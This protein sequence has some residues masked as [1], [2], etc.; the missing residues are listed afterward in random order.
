M[1]HVLYGLNHGTL[2]STVVL[3]LLL[4]RRHDFDRPGDTTTRT[5]VAARLLTALAAITLYA[6][7]ALWLNRMAADQSFSIR[8]A[9]RETLDGLTGQHLQG[10]PHFTGGFAFERQPQGLLHEPFVARH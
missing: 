10:S 4:A 8:F 7:S 2:A 9:V 1:L 6:L 5:L 3:V